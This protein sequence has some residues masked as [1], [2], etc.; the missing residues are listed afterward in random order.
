MS[1]DQSASAN[2]AKLFACSEGIYLL[3]HSV[4]RIPSGAKRH[5]TEHFFDAWE[6]ADAEPW[7]QWMKII[8]GFNSSLSRL[9]NANQDEFCP[10]L[11][12]SSALTKL[13]GALPQCEN[14]NTILLSEHDFPSIGFVAHQA[15]RL[16]LR[17]KWLPRGFNFVDA[18]AWR[19]HLTSDLLAVLVTHV[20][21]DTNTRVP[22]DEITSIARQKDVFSIIDVAQSAGI[23]PIDFS[24]WQADAV[25]GSCVKWL[26]GGPGAGFLWLDAG[27][28]QL[29]Q[30][31]DVGWFSHQNPFEFDIHN[32]EY[33]HHA[34]R[35][36]GGT[37]SVLPFDL[38]R[39]SVNQ[40]CDIGVENIFS[41]NRA[42]SNIVLERFDNQNVVNPSECQHRGGTLV[43][44]TKNQQAVLELLSNAGVQCDAR[45][46]G[47]RLSPHIYNTS[48]QMQTVA[49]YLVNQ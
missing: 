40:I 9:F 18:A 24:D 47:L 15:T 27:S 28:M 17:L 25:I 21:Y 49:D 42:M 16:G 39:F 14:K 45:A 19:K 33:A 11:N 4:G 23:V 26:C 12:L 44:K 38:A 10:Q 48:A 32:F 5:V 31:T 46:F 34:S 20:H 36:M 6:H 1:T 3:S 43:L 22:V 29:L 35:F 41:H 30:P 37:P 7:G 8:D 2:A 13:L